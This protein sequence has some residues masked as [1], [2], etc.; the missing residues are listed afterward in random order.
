M[1]THPSLTFQLSLDMNFGLWCVYAREVDTFGSDTDI[2]IEIVSSNFAMS[3][4]KLEHH[5]LL[6]WEKGYVSTKK[7][8]R[9]NGTPVFELH[10]DRDKDPVLAY[11]GAMK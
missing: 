1:N 7:A 5:R 11:L 9:S 2:L 6:F 3:L 10:L 8:T 4:A